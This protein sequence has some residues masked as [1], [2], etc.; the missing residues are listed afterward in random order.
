[1]GSSRRTLATILAALAAF[2]LLCAIVVGYATL[3][4]FDADQFADRTVAALDDEAVQ[5]EIGIRVTD[6]L[7]LNAQA[8]LVS[9]RPL[10]Q[11]VVS[12]I[13][14]GSLFQSLFRTAAGDVHRAVF[15]QD[16]DTVTLTL[17][18]IGSVLAGALQALAPKLSK[19]FGGDVDVEVTQ[20]D[21][22][23]WLA[24]LA[25]AA[26]GV[27]LLFWILLV[28][29]IVLAVAAIWLSPDRRRTVLGLGVAIVILGVVA[30]VAMTVT[31]GLTVARIDEAAVRDAVGGIWDA[32]LGDLQT[33]LY[34]FAGCGTVI[35]AAASSLLR[36]VDIAAPL[37]SA[38]ELIARVPE[39]TGARVL[40]AMIL[41]GVGIA[42][43]LLRAQ[44]LELFVIAAGLYVAYAGVS[45]L[46]RM[47]MTADEA[48]RTTR[49]SQGRRTLIATAIVAG[50]IIL[51]GGSFVALGGTKEESLE[52][53]T[54][55]CNGSQELC[56]QPLDQVAFA[57]THNAMSATSNEG[58]LFGMQEAGFA[59]QLRDGIR[60]LLI[61]AHY[62]RPTEGGEIKTDLSDLS[63]S[64]RATYERE[65]GTE[66]LEAA[67][68][69]R[70]R[71]VNS[72]TTGERGVYLCHRFCELGA[73][74]I[75]DA[76]RTYRDFLAANPDEV[77]VIVI[78]D[79]VGPED[80]EAAVEKSGLIDYVYDGPVGPPWP[81]LQEM[82]DSGG[83]ALMMAENDAGGGSIPWYHEVYDE[84]VQE[85]PFRFKK[86]EALT[87]RRQR[88]AS[89]EPNR[90]PDDAT[91]FLVNHWVDT[92]PAP[93]PSNA[94]IVNAKD[95]LLRRIHRCERIR[96]LAAGLVAVDFYRQGDLFDV[97]EKLNAERVGD[98]S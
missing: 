57:A 90:G 91:L 58:F 34:L 5:E 7:V 32:F 59:D 23:S 77:L 97:V 35:A 51:A 52:I 49:E 61:D 13:V 80:I 71:V 25:Q 22:P 37:R 27:E 96:G 4:L 38:G 62:G 84:L 76:F 46:M 12:G 48:E 10:I 87:D 81:T 6:D 11:G 55:G 33:A 65:L 16:Q 43:I 28:L 85:T 1:V 69:I 45:E 74:P 82:I 95:V 40:R 15:S 88:A 18:D 70:D 19:Q 3:A 67:L 79:Y 93:K 98:G 86:P 47:T 14:G 56:D 36:P 64:E 60:A 44:V 78:E 9:A 21:P 31:R 8:D 54:E 83:R 20:I 41:L 42:I 53:E 50:A 17:A 39:R 26:E 24:D 2:T 73:V 66:S 92:S 63:G 30:A 68:R 94:K 29:G 89:C 75:V 72:P